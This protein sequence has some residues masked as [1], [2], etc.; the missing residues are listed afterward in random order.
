MAPLFRDQHPPIVAKPPNRN[1]HSAALMA[2]YWRVPLSACHLCD[3]L[4]GKRRDVARGKHAQERCGRS[5]W[6]VG[7]SASWACSFGLS[8]NDAAIQNSYSG[9]EL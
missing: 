4:V 3:Q 5:C 7:S 8:H 9:D 1:M 2:G 6:F